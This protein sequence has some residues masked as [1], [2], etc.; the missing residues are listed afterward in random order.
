[1]GAY[2]KAEVWTVCWSGASRCAAIFQKVDVP[3]NSPKSKLYTPRALLAPACWILNCYS[4]KKWKKDWINRVFFIRAARRNH[5][6]CKK[7]VEAWLSL[8]T[9]HLN[10]LKDFWSNVPWTEIPAWSCLAIMHTAMPG[11]SQTHHDSNIMS[12]HANCQADWWRVENLV[13]FF[14]ATAPGHVAV[15]GLNSSVYKVF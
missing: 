8:K 13:F 2:I 9:L 12:G 14:A 7:N 4:S 11:K 6:L 10:K 5:L 15:I 1:M 3:T